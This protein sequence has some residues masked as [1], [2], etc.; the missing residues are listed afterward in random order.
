M[1]KRTSA[2]IA[3]ALL[4]A[5]AIPTTAEP[6]RG[7]GPQRGAPVLA[8]TVD[9]LTAKVD[10]LAATVDALAARV[11]DLEEDNA[12]LRRTAERLT[13]DV[14][15]LLATDVNRSRSLACIDES[16]SGDRVL[17]LR[18]CDLRFQKNSAG[19]GGKMFVHEI[20]A[21]DNDIL[22]VRAPDSLLLQSGA[23]SVVLNRNGDI[24]IRGKDIDIDASMGIDIKATRDVVIKGSKIQDN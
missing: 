12:A 3:G 17:V 8:A 23:A 18:G 20:F 4:L 22:T 9:T 21:S 6:T 19:A 14:A 13:G 24:S 10:A 16:Q 5:W 1:T 11:E 7:P 15:F 2:L